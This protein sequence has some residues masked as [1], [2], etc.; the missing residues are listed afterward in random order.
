MN[1]EQ[2]KLMHA[3]CVAMISHLTISADAA[4]NLLKGYMTLSQICETELAHMRAEEKRLRGLIE[5]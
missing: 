1:N 4:A 2:L 5:S 3:S